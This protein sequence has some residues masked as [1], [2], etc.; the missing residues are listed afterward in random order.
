MTDHTGPI[1]PAL[2]LPPHL[3]LVG[4]RHGTF[5]YPRHDRYVGA[6]LEAYGEFSEGEA[7]L[8]C[9][10]M[11]V[12]GVIVE[13]GA[14]IGALTVPLAKAAGPNGLVYAYEPQRPLYHILCANL[15]LNGL[16]NVQARQMGIGRA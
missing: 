2:L 4:G 9:R 14:N 16:F 11:P 15:A 3:G 8:L 1:A 13:A 5:L 10:V 6:S 12:G 7:D